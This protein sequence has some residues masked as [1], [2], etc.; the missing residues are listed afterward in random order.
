MLI[1][2]EDI[3]PAVFER[4]MREL[5][6][7]YRKPAPSEAERRIQQE[8]AKR[9]QPK[10]GPAFAHMA[11]WCGLGI[12]AAVA[13]AIPFQVANVIHE[14]IWVTPLVFW[15][16]FGTGVAQWVGSLKRQMNV[17]HSDLLAGW[18]PHLELSR[19]ERAYCS[20]LVLLSKPELQVSEET[21]RSLLAEL[22]ALMEQVRKLDAR[23]TE[24]GALAAGNEV[25]A[26]EGERAALASRAASAADPM[27][28]QTF[29]EGLRLCDQRLENARVVAP[30]I[31]R[32]DAQQEMILQTLG[33]IHSSLTRLETAHQALSVADA[34]DI[35]RQIREITARAAAVEGAVQE[36]QALKG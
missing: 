35:R 11:K 16:V 13:V 12:A 34:D 7:S 1:R 17:V 19:A 25:A 8:E 23:R 22:N 21:A 28:R 26:I 6:A 5:T 4:V 24:L 18:L 32:L 10:A 15:G 31:E 36:V 2:R 33:S 3:D 27:A 14:A 9:F 20:A 30:S 29:E